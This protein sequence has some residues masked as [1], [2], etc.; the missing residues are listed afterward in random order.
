VAR[1]PPPVVRGPP[2]VVRGPWSVSVVRPPSSVVRLSWSVLRGPSPWSVSVVRGPWLRGPS[3]VVRPPWSVVRL[4]IFIKVFY[5]L[6]KQ[7]DVFKK[8]PYE[9]KAE[10]GSEDGRF[11]QVT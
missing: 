10:V 2:P 8:Y 3:P 4:M 11:E 5:K 6:N 1:G 7:E 9:V